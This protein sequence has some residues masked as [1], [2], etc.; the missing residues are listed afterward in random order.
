MK[1]VQ[2]I[3]TLDKVIE[4]KKS[5]LQ[6]QKAS[7]QMATFPEETAIRA[8]IDFVTLNVE[9]LQRISADLKAVTEL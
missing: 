8:T 3:E 1:L 5:Y 9:E 2:V 7:L 4:Q 6:E